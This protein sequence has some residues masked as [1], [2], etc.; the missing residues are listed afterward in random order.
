M[1]QQADELE[2]T[3]ATMERMYGL[4]QQLAGTTHHMIGVTKETVAITGEVRDHLADFD[5]FFR[6]IRNYFYWEP[7]CFNIPICWAFRSL[8]DS[9]DGVDRLTQKLEELDPDLDNIDAIMPQ[10]VTLLPPLIDSVKSLRTMML[11]MHSTM[12]GIFEQM[13]ELERQRDCHGAGFRR[14]QKRRLL[15]PASGGVRQP[16]LPARHEAVPVTGREGSA[17]HHFA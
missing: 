16:G 1:L 7:H 13:E 2:D 14:R 10:L 11:T 15:L 8:Y 12:S 9:L 5:D 6:P 17:L 4:T 3:I